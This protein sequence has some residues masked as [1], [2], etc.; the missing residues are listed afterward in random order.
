MRVILPDK[1]VREYS[2]GSRTVGQIICDLGMNPV[3]TLVVRDGILMPESA[4]PDDK[5]EIH[6]IMVSHGG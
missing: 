5:D 3:E 6:I 4:I 1:T 2:P